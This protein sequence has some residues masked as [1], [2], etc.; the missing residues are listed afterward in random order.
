VADHSYYAS[1]SRVT[2]PGRF[3]AAVEEV[4]GSLTEMR[5]AARELVFHYRGGGDW[6]ENG[7]DA[8]RIA[9]IDT[10]YAEAMLA[11]LDQ[12]GGL[13]LTEARKPSQRL[14]GCC[15]DFTVL[16]LTLARQ[17]GIPSRARVGFA[18]YFDAGWF[19]DH[20][21]A[22]VWDDGGQ[23]W[24]LVDAE[25]ADDHVDPTDGQRVDPEDLAGHFLTGPQAWQ[26]CRSG[27]A[28]PDKFL[29][30]QEL[31][32]P[33]LRGWPY[34]RHNLIHDLASLSKREMVL[35]DDWGI[36]LDAEQTPE[37]LALLDDLAATTVRAA[38]PD[39][40]VGFYQRDN[41]RV[42]PVVTSY[43]PAHQEPLQVAVEAVTS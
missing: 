19:V 6:A 17:H 30:D 27:A 14:V 32:I 42:P 39:E 2:D 5:R 1:Q 35:W 9:E 38:P 43:S 12:L 21:V 18:T 28:D 16:F 25:L 29:V 11:R 13:R 3:A 31:D 26:A 7:I 36:M 34:L 8:E 22:E 37:Q 40:I 41:L 4:P 24:R 20:V 23:R 33:G 10:R 15:R